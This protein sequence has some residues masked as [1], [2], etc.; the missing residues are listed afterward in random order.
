MPT[1]VADLQRLALD[2]RS[3][4]VELVQKC[5]IAASKL[6]VEQL[7]V[8]ARRELDGYG[9]EEVPPY[10]TVRGQPVVFNPYQGYQPLVASTPEM[11][12]TLSTMP[13]NQPIGEIEHAL[14][15]TQEDMIIMGYNP[16]FE[17]HLRENIKFRLTPALQLSK[18]QLKKIIDGVRKVVLEW[19]LVLEKDNVVGEGMS[20]TK[21]EVEVA[22]Q[23]A[24]NVQNYF[25][26]PID[27]SQIQIDTV[28]S[29]QLQ[30]S[31][32]IDRAALQDLLERL[33]ALL[34]QGN[35]GDDLAA[36]LRAD[37]AT[38]K[39]QVSAPRP[40]RDIVRIALGSV[41][42]IVEGVV[43]DL[44]KQGILQLLGRVLGA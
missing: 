3:S 21:A 12:Q 32:T 27:H 34:A 13:F 31:M 19:T 2:H 40:N 41:R 43:T 7:A 35:I 6:D 29:S 25:A 38:L 4:I 33:D 22:R 15:D 14:L 39:A 1:L 8:W 44:A 23:T 5:L 28:A 9:D 17:A 16:E 24:F 30:A 11:A 42:S 18:S 10:R 26:G 36:D 37:I 20:F